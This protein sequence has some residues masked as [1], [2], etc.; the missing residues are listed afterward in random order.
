[1]VSSWPTPACGGAKWPHCGCA[2]STCFAAVSTCPDRSPNPVAGLVDTEDIGAPVCALPGSTGRRTA[3][4]DGRTRAATIWCSPTCA[5]GSC[6][7]PTGGHG[8]SSPAVRH[9][10]S[11]ESFPT[12]TSHDLR[13]TAA[14]GGVCR[15]QRQGSAADAWARQGVDDA[16]RYADLFDDDL[17]GVA[18]RCWTR[19]SDLLRPLRS[20]ADLLLPH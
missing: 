14:P 4:A 3:S 1:M 13:H 16:G 18:D 19:Q 10:R 20:R 6:G 11:D 5:A 2:I 8:C 9:A 17:D 7:T 15:C 12:I